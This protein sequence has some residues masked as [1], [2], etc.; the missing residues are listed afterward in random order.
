MKYASQD[1]SDLFS[2]FHTIN[3][4][5]VK[6]E[7]GTWKVCGDA[8][9]MSHN[10]LLIFTRFAQTFRRRERPTLWPF[11]MSSTSGRRHLVEALSLGIL[12]QA[13]VATAGLPVAVAAEHPEIISRD[14][15]SS[16][17]QFQLLSS[18]PFCCRDLNHL[19]SETRLGVPFVHVD[20]ILHKHQSDDVEH[21]NPRMG[22]SATECCETFRLLK[23]RLRKG[24][25]SYPEPVQS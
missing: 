19:I 15:R 4:A 12:R 1:S 16:S 2:V 24:L 13:R 21:R 8:R 9:A 25:K 3:L 6:L 17:P 10:H 7:V 23:P 18:P 5:N 11:Q 22:D 14:L 20:A